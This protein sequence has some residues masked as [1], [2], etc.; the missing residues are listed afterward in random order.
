[1]NMAIANKCSLL[2]LQKYTGR[3]RDK[4]RLNSRV[5]GRDADN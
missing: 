3:E 5:P 4:Y 2:E 1:M